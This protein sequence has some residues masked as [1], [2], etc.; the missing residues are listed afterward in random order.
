MDRH[1]GDRGRRAPCDTGGVPR[2]W[3][4]HGLNNG[5]IFSATDPGVRRLPRPR[6]R[7]RSAHGGTWLTAWRDAAPRARHSPT[8][9][10]GASRTSADA[11]SIAVARATLRGYA[12]D[13]V[14][15]LRALARPTRH[16]GLFELPPEHPRG[17]MR[18]L[19]QRRGIILVTGHYGN[20]EIGSS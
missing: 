10:R 8:I 13:I 20:W 4:L 16:G 14:D 5:A 12:R 19:A 7:T 9:S 15:F 17:F 18:L 3:T 6:A 1:A 11:R 2:R